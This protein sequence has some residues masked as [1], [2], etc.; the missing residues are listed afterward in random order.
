MEPLE[1][2]VASYLQ[3]A[4]TILTEQPSQ[5]L[6]ERCSFLESH[7][8]FSALASECVKALALPSGRLSSTSVN[9]ASWMSALSAF[10]RRAEI[11]LQCVTRLPDPAT[12]VTKL[13]AETARTECTLRYLVLVDNIDLGKAS[14]NWGPFALRWLDPSGFRSEIDYPTRL[15]FYPHTLQGIEL[16]EN[17]YFVE[18]T[19]T[20]PTGIKGSLKGLDWLWTRTFN[21]DLH[22]TDFPSSVA[23]VLRVL[24]L[25]DWQ[26]P[27]AKE[28]LDLPLA[29][30]TGW[31]TFDFPAI[32][33]TTDDQLMPYYSLPSGHG[34]GMEPVLDNDGNEVGEWPQRPI[35]ELDLDEI[36][37]LD[38]GVQARSAELQSIAAHTEA[39][40]VFNAM[41]FLLKA[42][43]S[44]GMEQLLWNVVA[45]EAVLGPESKN[46]ESISASLRRRVAAILGGTNA[47]QKAI[48]KEVNDLYGFRSLLVHGG[49]HSDT[50]FAG[51][52]ASARRIARKVVDWALHTFAML[53]RNGAE[54]SSLPTRVDLMRLLDLN[55]SERIRL[56]SQLS[57]LPI[58]FPSI[59][60][61]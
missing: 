8:S 52:V 23:E 25:H 6:A 13:R 45:I 36:H 18:V 31:S 56:M 26:P 24:A 49:A 10:F 44:K 1:A 30:R 19:R 38:K 29:Q 37:S 14:L 33:T 32:V 60:R 21:I 54:S 59:E 51:H 53:V 41:D 27:W 7:A 11:Y 39:H 4:R 61:S 12:V 28:E 50:V 2:S 43:L 47:Q 55:P 40:F 15:A 35:C 42:F 9:Q 57:S 22:V 16:F 3:A 5:A 46:M 17:H 20:I 34:I 48:S 58:T